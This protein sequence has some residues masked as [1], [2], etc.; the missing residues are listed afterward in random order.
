MKTSFTFLSLCLLLSA[1]TQAQTNLKGRIIDGRNQ[2]VPFANV[3]LLKADSTFITGTISGDSGQFR[4]AASQQAAL[5]KVSYVGYVDRVLPIRPGKSNF[6]NI[7]LL[8]NTQL[9]GE[10]VV[11]GYLPVTR[12]KG[13]ALQTTV[14]GTILEK[15]GTANDV[16]GKLPSVTLQDEQL[17]VFGRGTPTVYI[18]GREVRD[19]SD[20][21]QLSSDNIKSVEVISNPGA[22]YAK[23]VKAVIRI[24]T[25]A[26]DDGFGVSDRAYAQ[27]NSLWTF[28]DQLNLYYRKGKF[29]AEGMAAF[30]KRGG[31]RKADIDENSYLSNL[32]VQQMHLHHQWDIRH[33]TATGL[34]NY[35]FNA[36]HSIGL[37]YRFYR[38]MREQGRL[39]FSADIL[40]DNVL[41]EHSNSAATNNEQ[42]TNHEA[43]LY[44]AGKIGDWSLNFNGT[45]LHISGNEPSVSLEDITDSIGGLTHNAVH[46]HSADRST[47]YAAKLDLS[48]PLWKG[49]LSFG[50][51]YSHTSRTSDY[52]NDEGLLSNSNILVKEQLAAAYAEYARSFGKLQ[53]QAGLRFENTGFDYYESGVYRPEQSRNYNKLFPSVSL[54][55]P[56]RTVQL[57]ASYTSDITRPSYDQLGNSVIYI[58]RYTYDQGNPSLYPN[59]NNSFTLKATYRWLQFYVSWEHKMDEINIYEVSYNGNPNIA[60]ETYVNLPTYNDMAANLSAS[61]TFGAWQPRWELSLYKQ[62]YEVDAPGEPEGTKM[63]LGRMMPTL[64]WQN[65][66]HLPWQLL[67]GANVSWSGGGDSGN[68][69]YKH[70][71]L[72]SASLYR[73]FFDGKLDILLRTNDPFDIER[74]N[75]ISYFGSLR[76]MNNYNNNNGHQ[77]VGLTLTYKFNQKKSKYKGTGAGAEQ[78]GRM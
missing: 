57:Q 71:W 22:R 20:L 17:N 19:Q 56:I 24:T 33:L 47:L 63:S 3:I 69:R 48:Y 29:D 51:E 75:A 14:A 2:P 58:N 60:L 74:Y 73:E 70:E 40:K 68:M 10:V 28:N 78:K 1:A 46:T 44:Y 59:I 36:K 77:Y 35:T 61:P 26:F 42:S 34:L 62:W 13:E 55:L 27:Y 65:S 7:R 30:E 23:S 21:D 72:T 18:N 50:G 54:T 43:D 38:Q 9:L 41:Y 16:L 49:N 5:L 4:I 66:I 6:G 64:R 8:E 39:R 11:K 15:A 45:Y 53:A 12:I 25:K 37:N 52:V 67:L 31:W 32:W 76:T